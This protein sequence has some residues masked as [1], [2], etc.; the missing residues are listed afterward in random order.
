MDISFPLGAS[1]FPKGR[2]SVINSFGPD[3][4]GDFSASVSAAYLDVWRFGAALTGYYGPSAGFL[5][6]NNHFNMK[7]DLSDRYNVSFNI[8]RTFGVS[9]KSGRK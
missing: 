2:S 5:G 6:A 1:F 4:G 9:Y 8:R 7:Q 3:K